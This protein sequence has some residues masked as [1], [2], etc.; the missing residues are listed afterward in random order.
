MSNPFVDSM[1]TINPMN[2]LIT[3]IN[4]GV[5]PQQLAQNILN[6]NPQ[7]VQFVQSMQRQC[8]NN[9]PRDYVLSYCQQNGIN[10]DA[11]LSLANSLGIR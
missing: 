2:N 10:K 1:Q 3:M 11:V 9:S 6:N 7:A 4:Q 5:N 8:G